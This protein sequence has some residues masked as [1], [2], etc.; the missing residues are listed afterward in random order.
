EIHMSKR[1]QSNSKA[2]LCR[3]YYKHSLQSGGG[4]DFRVKRAVTI[5]GRHW[6]TQRT[7]RRCWSWSR[8]RRQDGR[9]RSGTADIRIIKCVND[10]AVWLSVAASVPEIT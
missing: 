6:R 10:N 4:I 2:K 8:A 9:S 5:A 7:R 1:I 3:R